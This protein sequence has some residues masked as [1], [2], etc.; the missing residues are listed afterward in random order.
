MKRYVIAGITSALMG[1]SANE[2]IATGKTIDIGERL[3][4]IR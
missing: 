3:D 4:K 1:I 2:S